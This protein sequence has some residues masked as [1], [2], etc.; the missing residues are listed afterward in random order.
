MLFST[1][2]QQLATHKSRSQLVSNFFSLQSQDIEAPPAE[3]EDHE[4]G[5]ADGAL[6]EADKVA[7]MLSPT[8]AKHHGARVLGF[9]PG[10][11]SWPL[12]R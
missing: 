12:Q 10:E 6:E 7:A 5:E 11:V 4:D 2:L 3:T 1:L 9:S 8:G